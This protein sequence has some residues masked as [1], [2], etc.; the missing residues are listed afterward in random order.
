M[1]V[2]VGLDIGGSAVRAAALDTAKGGFVLRRFGS[3]PLPRGAVIAGDV[4]DE[5]AVGE[6]IVA[7][8]KRHKLPRRRVVLGIASQRLVVRRIDVPQLD[9]RE[10]AEALPYQVQDSIPIPPEEAILDFVPLERFVTPEGEPMRSILVVAI[11]RETVD[12]MLRVLATARVRP[13]AV[14]LQAF[15]LSRSVLGLGAELDDRLHALVDI[16][17]TLTQIVLSRGATPEFV[18]FVPMGGD[19]F[20]E[21]LV[22][23]LDL[24]WATAQERKAAVGVVPEG[25]PQGDDPDSR[26]RRILTREGDRLIDEIRTS[27]SFHL[28][29]NAHAGIDDLVVAG[30]GARLPHLANR[31]GLALDV[32]VRPAKVLDL[33][34]VG[35]VDLDAEALQEAQPVLPVAVGLALWGAL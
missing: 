8:F 11:H 2:T 5:G 33:V 9:D 13:Q 29:E 34:D 4:Q 28:A 7:L 17:A 22:R 14:D 12:G 24:D 27:V 1:P 3:M 21:A 18:R 16:G 35:G 19:D 15:A 20:T 25:A 32:P 10:L 30:N 6:A 31:L 26:L 23:D